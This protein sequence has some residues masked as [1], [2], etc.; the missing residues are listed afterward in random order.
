MD[1][2]NAQKQFVSIHVGKLS[3]FQLGSS[4]GPSPGYSMQNLPCTKLPNTN[5]Y[6]AIVY[7]A[8]NEL[9]RYLY[10]PLGDSLVIS[11]V[12]VYAN[13]SVRPTMPTDLASAQTAITL[14][15]HPVSTSA[16]KGSTYHKSYY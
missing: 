1:Y 3:D 16:I 15:M 5:Y 7:D 13:G 6:Q 4:C 12:T 14:N 10:Y 2:T 9:L 8:S 11:S